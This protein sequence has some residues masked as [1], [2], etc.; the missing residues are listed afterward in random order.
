VVDEDHDKEEK[1][2]NIGKERRQEERV[3]QATTGSLDCLC[4]CETASQQATSSA[5]GEELLKKIKTRDAA[6]GEK[7]PPSMAE[8]GKPLSTGG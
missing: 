4:V 6:A 2:K 1:V 8:K 3:G 7:E 5:I